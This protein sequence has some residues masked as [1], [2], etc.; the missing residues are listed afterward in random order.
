SE[1]AHSATRTLTESAITRPS[2]RKSWK[3]ADSSSPRG[4]KA[5]IAKRRS[6]K[7]P[8]QRSVVS[9]STKTS[10]LPAKTRRA[11][12]AAVDRETFARFLLSPTE[13]VL[14]DGGK[15]ASTH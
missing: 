7:K 2:K 3:K 9:R 10:I 1:L 5:R 4:V 11:W 13:V 14:D 12:F 6:K 8:K 15:S